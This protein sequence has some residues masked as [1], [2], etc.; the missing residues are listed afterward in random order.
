MGV[1]KRTQNKERKKAQIINAAKKL[2][3]KHGNA[4]FTM[5]ELANQ[6]KVALV[7]P[8]S[9]FQSKAGV[10]SAV[11]DPDHALEDAAAWLDDAEHVDGFEKLM[12]F[13]LSRC[14]RYIG[15]ASVYRAVL[16][17]LLKLEPEIAPEIRRADDWLPLWEDGLRIAT[18]QGRINPDVSTVIAAHTI[19]S[20][21]L[22]ILERW[23][24]QLTTDD[25]LLCE[26]R[27]TVSLM[28]AGLASKPADRKKWHER[29]MQAQADVLRARDMTF[30]TA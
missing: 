12:A 11:L 10:L 23:V 9:Y 18:E 4:D 13:A 17:S 3:A 30:D 27:M 24:K 15:E 5:P 22:G 21:F 8:Y 14:E 26:T 1:S 25:L 29:M 20:A 2:I 16:F 28:L 7:T 19:R 6:A